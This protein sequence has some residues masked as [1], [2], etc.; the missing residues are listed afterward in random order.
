MVDSGD[1]VPDILK[2]VIA[3]GFGAGKTTFVAALSEIESLHT[4]ELITTHSAGTDD[5]R[6]LDQKTTTTV[7]LD[8]GR[9]TLDQSTVIY[10]FGMPGQDRF[11][12][13]WD[14]LAQGALGAVVLADTRR[15]E[16]C[17][18]SID[19]FENRG[20]PFVVAINCFDGYR[21]HLPEDV[22][23]ALSLNTDVPLML[24][25]ARRRSSV[26][27]VLV[28]LVGHVLEQELMRA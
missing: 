24:C 12:F 7:A 20:L 9:V 3:G 19:Y 17:F 22:R 27:T 11:S 14:E 28:E 21:S 23:T 16:D 4:E 2:I 25:D 6:G 15:L 26:K 5:L 10:M 13:M 8:F 18:P 1:P